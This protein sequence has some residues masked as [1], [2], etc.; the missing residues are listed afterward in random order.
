MSSVSKFYLACRNG[1]FATV[2]KLL[3]NMSDDEKNRTEPNGSTALH[4]AT[5]YGHHDIVKLLLENGCATWIRNNYKN[6]PYDEAQDEEMRELFRRPNRANGSNR[7]ASTDDCFS[8]VTRNFGKDN[9]EIDGDDNISKGW[10]KGYKHIG[11]FEERET[12]IKQIVHAQMMKYCLKKFQISDTC[13]DLL[14]LLKK[15]LNADSESNKQEDCRL[16]RSSFEKFLTEQ[17][18]DELIRVYTLETAFYGALQ[19][20]GD[21]F[22]IELYSRLSSLQ[23]RAFKGGKTYRGL[24]TT[25][26]SLQVYRWAAKDK[27]RMIEIRTMTSTSLLD[28][29]AIRFAKDSIANDKTKKK[30]PIL[31]II[32]FPEVCYTAID[33]N[34]DKPIT[35]YPHEQEILLL[36][37]TLFEVHD[38]QDGPMNGWYTIELTNVPVPHKILKKALNEFQNA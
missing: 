4:A 28:S 15:S 1:D 12:N 3:P 7:F 30:L 20:K 21:L 2:Q 11:T 18:V 32:E 17:D 35:K 24:G 5:Y 34:M 31:Y 8:I 9:D 22:A 36:P 13:K 29:V 14:K 27:S 16:A 10:V 23:D 25:D 33:L 19:T 37:G 6:T 26:D 38:V